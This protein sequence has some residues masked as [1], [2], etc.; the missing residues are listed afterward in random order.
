MYLSFVDKVKKSDPAG[1]LSTILANDTKNQQDL[2]ETT[3]SFVN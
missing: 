3:I 1:N 2:N